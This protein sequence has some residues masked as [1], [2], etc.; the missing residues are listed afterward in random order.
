MFK[1]FKNTSYLESNV[2]KNNVEVLNLISNIF[3][4]KMTRYV[5]KCAYVTTIHVLHEQTTVFSLSK[6]KQTMYFKIV[7][8]R[9]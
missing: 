1:Y 6:Q 8:D 9:Y 5:L 7:P 3:S 4:R 2:S